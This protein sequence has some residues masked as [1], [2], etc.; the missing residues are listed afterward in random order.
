MDWVCTVITYTY[1]SNRSLP[2]HPGA[3]LISF[4]P[5]HMP[6]ISLCL[7][8]VFVLIICVDSFHKDKRQINW[9]NATKNGYI[10]TF[11]E[12]FLSKNLCFSTYSRVFYI[13]SLFLE[14]ITT[15]NYLYSSPPFFCTLP[16]LL[17]ILHP[18]INYKKI[19][20]NWKE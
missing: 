15:Q 4:N 19:T 13:C 11:V 2:P 16:Y 7:L 1:R 5:V 3:T 17:T 14:N 12:C 8:F 20:P 6:R 9:N 18:Q 10:I